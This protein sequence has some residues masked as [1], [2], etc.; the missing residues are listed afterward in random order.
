MSSKKRTGVHFK[1]NLEKELNE[2]SLM[3][4]PMKATKIAIYVL[5]LIGQG[6]IVMKLSAKLT[7]YLYAEDS[8]LDSLMIPGLN[9]STVF[10]DGSWW[11]FLFY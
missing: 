3:E 1:A 7:P 9:S 11:Q 10:G 4:S 6:K 5:S 2:E 8:V